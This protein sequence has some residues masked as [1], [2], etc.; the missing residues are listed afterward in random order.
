M[1]CSE[2]LKE[3]FA[4]R[5]SGRVSSSRAYSRPHSSAQGL[6]TISR[7]QASSHRMPVH[8]RKEPA[9]EQEV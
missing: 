4:R 7:N 8:A 9:G 5:T 2:A 1:V 6:G 3:N